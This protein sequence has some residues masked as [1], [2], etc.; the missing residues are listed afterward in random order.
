MEIQES[1]NLSRRTQEVKVRNLLCWTGFYI[2]RMDLEYAWEWSGA[3]GRDVCSD[4]SVRGIE[5]KCGRD[6]VFRVRKYKNKGEMGRGGVSPCA[7]TIRAYVPRVRLF[8]MLSMRYPEVSGKL[9]RY[10]GIG[11]CIRTRQIRVGRK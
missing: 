7:I 3:Y 1:T 8:W 11:L 4:N 9:R 2:L 10:F 6:R 5:S